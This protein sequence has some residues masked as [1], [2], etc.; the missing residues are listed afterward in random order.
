MEK[1]K[2]ERYRADLVDKYEQKAWESLANYNYFGRQYSENE[3]LVK[4]MED[5]LAHAEAEIKRIGGLPDHNTVENRDKVKG[6]KKDVQMYKKRIDSIAPVMKKLFEETAAWREQG[7]KFL[8]QAENFKSFAVRTP[9][10]IQ[11][12]KDIKA[13]QLKS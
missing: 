11:A 13:Q 10:E 4:D 7:V 1:D 5:R 9:A 6:F 2:Q 3:K 8:E 12:D